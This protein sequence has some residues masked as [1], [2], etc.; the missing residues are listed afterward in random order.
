M[1]PERIQRLLAVGLTLQST[2]TMTN[3]DGTTTTIKAGPRNLETAWEEKYLELCAFK[4]QHGHL[5]ISRK[6]YKDNAQY[7]SLARWCG[8]QR[9]NYKNRLNKMQ[10]Q[11]HGVGTATAAT[12]TTTAKKKGQ[13]RPGTMTGAQMDLL[14]KIGFSF[15]K[16]LD[17]AHRF[18]QISHYKALYGDTR[19]PVAF[20]EMDGLGYWVFNQKKKYHAGRMRPD[21]IQLLQTIGFDF[22]HRCAPNGGYR[23][24]EDDKRQ[25]AARATAAS[26]PQSPVMDMVGI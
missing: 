10:Q 17:F 14:T 8:T 13:R 16:N 2:T 5:N 3:A 15:S 22:T 6:H 19:V 24:N 9:E 26:S 23:S 18:T 7:Q 20:K 21:R 12:T 25:P 1:T 4:E 11:Q